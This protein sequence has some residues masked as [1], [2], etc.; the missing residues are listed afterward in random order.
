[1]SSYIFRLEVD[2]VDKSVDEAKV[3]TIQENYGGTERLDDAG[4]MFMDAMLMKFL[5]KGS[6]GGVIFVSPSNGFALLHDYNGRTK[7]Q[8]PMQQSFAHFLYEIESEWCHQREK[9]GTRKGKH[10]NYS[11]R[12]T[13]C[14][15]VL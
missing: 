15:W 1:M 14:I 3:S 2:L 11:P 6:P 8:V 9:V 7:N 13:N 5:E 4:W 10:P 12:Y